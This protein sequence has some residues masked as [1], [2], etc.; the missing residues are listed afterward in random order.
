[1]LCARSYLPAPA[2]WEGRRRKRQGRK[3]GWDQVRALGFTVTFG[4]SSYGVLNGA[5]VH[6]WVF[7]ER[8]PKSLLSC[9]SLVLK[10]LTSLWSQHTLL[11]NPAVHL[12]LTKCQLYLNKAGKR[13][14][15][16]RKATDFRGSSKIRISL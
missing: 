1:M 2:P 10:A 3:W 16:A 6:R 14:I 9:F 11:P 12:K 5:T 7:T 15:K 13:Q 8:S 4:L